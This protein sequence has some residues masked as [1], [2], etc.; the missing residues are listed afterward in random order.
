[1]VS[2]SKGRVN[3]KL[4]TR[5]ALVETAARMIRDR[6]TFT[7]ADVADVARVGRTTAYRYFPT[8][9]ELVG[10]ATLWALTETED[11]QIAQARE[12]GGSFHERLMSIV[13]FSDASIAQHEAE[14][15]TMLKMSLEQKVGAADSLPRRS[16]LRSHHLAEALASLEGE[17]GARRFRTLCAGLSLFM[18][19][20]SSVVLRDVCLLGEDEARE[21]KFWGARVMLDAALAEARDDPPKAKPARKPAAVH[22]GEKGVAAAAAAA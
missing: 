13:A 10:H 21:V 9:D 17:L 11:A 14:Y 8:L 6:K 22:V 16:G 18:G 19:I 12:N 2:L 1:M 3:Q 7:V 5:N 20:E 4:R 15:R